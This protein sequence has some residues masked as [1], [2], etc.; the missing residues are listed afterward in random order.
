MLAPPRV[1]KAKRTTP[2]TDRRVVQLMDQLENSLAVQYVAMVR[3]AKAKLPEDATMS[4]AAG[5]V[6]EEA[7]KYAAEIA[8]AFVVV[9]RHEATVLSRQL[10][11]RIIFDPAHARAR[12]FA[13]TARRRF[14][15]GF[16]RE[17]SASISQAIV[18]AGRPVSSQTVAKSR[19]TK[20]KKGPAKDAL[21]LTPYQEQIVENYRVALAA[22]S[23]NALQRQLRDRRFD[24]TVVRAV[25]DQ[26]PLSWAQINRMTERYRERWIV[27]RAKTIARTQ[28]LM[29][30]NTARHEAL[31][32]AADQANFDPD[33]I[34][35]VWNATM[36]D[37]TRD[38]HAGLDGYSVQ[39]MDEPF[40]ADGGDLLYP[41]DP[42]GPPEEIINCRC[43]LSYELPG[44]ADEDEG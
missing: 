40:P 38:S 6:A 34:V 25:E 35:R 7:D 16:R 32:Q 42:D 39:G 44:E 4:Q 8:R 20:A 43:W 24:P 23:A 11:R 14:L 18:R 3:R 41:G 13:D 29:I 2:R 22:S 28:S 10:G 5:V 21:G 30:A 15:Q 33:N 19:I 17:Q 31:T 12:Q 36:D 26:E 9:G 27:Y 1:S 37:R